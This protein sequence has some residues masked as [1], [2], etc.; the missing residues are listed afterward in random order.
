VSERIEYYDAPAGN[1]RVEMPVAEV[2]AT[3]FNAFQEEFEQL[4]RRYSQWGI[5]MSV[6]APRQRS[7]IVDDDG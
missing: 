3:D 6:S 5:S 1:L 2:R 4:A 7:R